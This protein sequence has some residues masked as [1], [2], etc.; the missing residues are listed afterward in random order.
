[1]TAATS[2]ASD[3]FSG[4]VGQP[5]LVAQ[6]RAAAARPVHA[7]LLVGPP[8]AGT[9]VAA[10]AF[11]AALLCPDGGCR[12]CRHCRLVLAGE[13]PDATTFVPEGAFLRVS[14][15]DE[16][17]RVAM[18]SPLEGRRKVLVLADFH[19]VQKVGPALLKTIEEPP[20]STV[21]VLLAD[22]V[23]PE[24]V[25]IASRCVRIDV[26]PV[27][28]IALVEALVDEGVDVDAARVAAAASGGNLERARL[29]VSD[30]GVAARREAWWRV[31][32]RLDGS[33]AAVTVV[34]DELV[35]L[36]EAAGEPLRRAQA[37]S[38]EELDAKVA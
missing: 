3:V 38:M 2:E 35:A 27:G 12:R 6:L 24:L 14:D 22:T 13:H 30:T 10:R 5:Q 16:I 19:R 20:A 25:T 4:I 31:P 8:G 17:T 37:A 21:F 15:A 9:T 26:A 23:P 7:Y 32:E 11:A 36:V 34:V 33:G 29:L 1:M 18:R 28:A